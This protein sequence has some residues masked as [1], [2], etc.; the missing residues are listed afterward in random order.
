MHIDDIRSVLYNLMT[1]RLCLMFGKFIQEKI[2]NTPT[3]E[4]ER[5]ILRKFTEWNIGIKELPQKQLKR[6]LSW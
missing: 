4:T 1:Q 5:L 3:I 6:L 2:M